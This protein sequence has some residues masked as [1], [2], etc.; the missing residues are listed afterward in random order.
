MNM[1][2]PIQA[3][4]LVIMLSSIGIATGCQSTKAKLAGVNPLK[5]LNDEEVTLGV[6][7]RIVATWTEAVL[8]QSGTGTRGFGGRLYFYQRESAKPIRV[9]GQLVVYAFA[10]DGREPTDNRPTKR[11]VFP[12]QQF[13]RHEGESEIGVSYSVWLPWDAAG[14][15]QTEVSLIARFEPSQ[16]GGLVVS[17]QA[18]LRLPGTGERKTMIAEQSKPTN[19][20]QASAIGRRGESAAE[21]AVFESQTEKPKPRMTA[22]TISL[23]PR[24][25]SIGPA[26]AAA[27]PTPK[28]EPAPM[29]ATMDGAQAIPFGTTVDYLT[30][31]ESVR[32]SL[33]PRSF[34][35]SR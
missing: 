34:D 35:S 3:I 6:P 23:P 25:K 2:F 11:Y 7:E 26:T 21:Q 13:V 24:F 17:D 14:G 27:P 8:H 22:T 18:S 4:M 12:P 15:E 20:R 29:N 28:V 19:V 30:P 10:E 1:P 33:A 16:G 5:A 31:G 32:R 9:E